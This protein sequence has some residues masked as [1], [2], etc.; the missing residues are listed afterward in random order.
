LLNFVMKSN[1]MQITKLTAQQIGDQLREQGLTDRTVTKFTEAFI[2]LNNGVITLNDNVPNT[3]IPIRD[4][5]TDFQIDLVDS[6]K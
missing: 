6:A 2:Q 4:V 5:I 3:N 1:N